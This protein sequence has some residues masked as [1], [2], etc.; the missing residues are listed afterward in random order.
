MPTERHIVM[1]KYNLDEFSKRD[2]KEMI[3]RVWDNKFI[4]NRH[5]V[6]DSEQ[7]LAKWYKPI[8]LSQGKGNEQRQFADR[9]RKELSSFNYSS[10]DLGSFMNS[11]S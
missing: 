2:T 3:K 8:E 10:I 4:G 5:V 11:Y 6:V 1:S 7:S 9:I